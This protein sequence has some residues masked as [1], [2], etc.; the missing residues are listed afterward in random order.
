LILNIIYDIIK[1]S[2]QKVSFLLD[3]LLLS[4]SNSV[5]GIPADMGQK[6]GHVGL[7]LLRIGFG[8]TI[9]VTNLP[10]NT[11]FENLKYSP[12]LRIVAIALFIIAYKATLPLVLIGLLGRVCSTSHS[13]TFDRYMEKKRIDE[14]ATTIQKMIRGHQTRKAHLPQSLYPKYRQEVLRIHET[15][16]P[17]APLPGLAPVYLPQVMPDVI[18]KKC[19]R[20]KAVDRFH[21]MQVMRSILQSQHCTHLVVPEANL[22]EEYLIEKRLPIN[23]NLYHNMALYLSQP[24]SFDQAVRELTR[25]FSKATINDLIFTHNKG[26]HFLS[27]LDCNTGT[28]RF[29]NLPLYIVEENGKQVGKIGLIDLDKFTEESNPENLHILAQI[30]PYHLDTIKEEARKL[31]MEFVDSELDGKAEDG[32]RYFQLAYVDYFQ[33]Q[34][35]K[36]I[37][38]SSPLFSINSERIATLITL[39]EQELLNLTQGKLGIR[40]WNGDLLGYNFLTNNL[41]QTARELAHNYTASIINNLTNLAQAAY[42]KALLKQQAEGI[43]EQPMSLRYL[44]LSK[45]DL[46]KTATAELYQHQNTTQEE[47]KARDISFHLLNLIIQELVRGGEWFSCIHIPSYDFYCIRY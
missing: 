37:S 23:P 10:N 42:E 35:Q 22:C 46:C 21:Q 7:G 45:F 26:K 39:V 43:T 25:V 33:W 13:A 6:L 24:R 15:N 36:G 11:A 44:G 14:A 12:I 5:D 31:R 32:K 1:G 34:H 40:D 27:Y 20:R 19:G 28:I 3:R 16:E 17:R 18:L 2:K 8:K 4:Y 41:E 29:D 9:R 47:D 38:A 30:F